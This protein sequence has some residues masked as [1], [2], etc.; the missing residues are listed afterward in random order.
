MR[1]RLKNRRPGLTF[2]LP[3]PGNISVLVY[4]VMVGFD[5]AGT[6]KEVFISANKP[7]TAMDVAARDT[8]TL[9]SIA[10]QHGATIAELS[11]AM[12]RGDEG[13]PQGVAGAVLDAVREFEQGGA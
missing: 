2:T 9:I 11:A 10:L 8:A 1:S 4:D 12:T 7:T 5:E 3:H 13:E 6:P